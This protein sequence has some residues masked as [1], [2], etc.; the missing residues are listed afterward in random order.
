M[1][2]ITQHLNLN[3]LQY[4]TFFFCFKILA[5]L[6]IIML[7]LSCRASVLRFR[8]QEEISCSLED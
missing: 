6:L 1:D 8:K 5:Y 2:I 3:I 7:A 4:L